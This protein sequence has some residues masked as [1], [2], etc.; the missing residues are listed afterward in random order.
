MADAT[1]EPNVRPPLLDRLVDA[2]WRRAARGQAALSPARLKRALARDLE[3][4]LNTCNVYAAELEGYREASTSILAY[5]I[6]DLTPFSWRSERDARSIATAV[7]QQIRTHEP[8][9]VPRTVR[10]TLLPSKGVDDFSVSFRIDATLS[11]E[12]LREQVYFDS[13]IDLTTGELRVQ[14]AG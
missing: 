2:E 1:R 3:W 8:R 14:G 11:V 13:R 6:P 12:P 7:E 4:L 9:L 5:G 10:V